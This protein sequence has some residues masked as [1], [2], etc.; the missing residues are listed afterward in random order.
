MNKCYIVFAIIFFIFSCT[1]HQSSKNFTPETP[2]K[3]IATAIQPP[4]MSELVT[5]K[6]IKPM[7][8]K[9]V[10]DVILSKNSFNPSNREKVSLSFKLSKP[11]RVKVDLYDADAGLIWKHDINNYLTPGEQ[12]IEWNGKDIDGKIVPDEAYF[13][14]I[15]AEDENAEIEIYDPT[16]FSGGIE[17]DITN[18]H[19]DPQHYTIEYTM[20][21]LGRVLIRLGIQGGALMNQLVDWKLRVNG[22]I[23]EH[24]N[25]KDKDNLVELLE[26]PKFKMIISYFSLPENSVITYGNQEIS[27]SEYK[28][29]MAA[30]RPSKP[31]RETAITKRSHHYGLLRS[32]DYSPEIKIAFSNIHGETAEGLLILKDKSIVKVTLEDKDKAI[33]QNSQF[34]IC[35]FLNHQF[36]AEDET[37]YTPFNW[38]WDLSQVDPGDHLL[39]VN[40]S[41]F[42]DQIGVISRKVKVIR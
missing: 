16:T 29:T 25:G 15:V 37:G 34:E 41:S 22:V 18:A 33:F 2:P 30:G 40:I 3:K 28:R 12:I 35:F 1:S 24:W 5:R 32:K 10:S 31:K 27:F 14:T 23:T 17:H 7:Y 11:A 39:T 4:D 9:L 8:G 26:H 13:F 42:D 38:V 36:F 20:P 21:E 6:D 19:I